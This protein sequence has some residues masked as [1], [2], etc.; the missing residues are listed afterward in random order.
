MVDTN[1]LVGA[2][3]RQGEF[4]RRVI[5]GCLNGEYK[6]VIGAAL[7]TEYEDVFSRGELWT[8]ALVNHAE[9][10]EV[11][12]AF[13]SVCRWVE[14]YFAWHPNL[15]DEG[16]NH[17]VELAVSANAAAIVTRNVR[18]LTRGE[19][20]FPNISIMTSEELL[21]KHPCQH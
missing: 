17:L 21:E 13:L 4:A 11:L 5:R 8:G 7:F 6:P 2:V 3:M 20:R 18:D 10:E 9:R 14:V 19:L 15:P 1:V 12:N 16:D